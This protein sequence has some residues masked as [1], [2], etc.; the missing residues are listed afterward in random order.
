V[1]LVDTHLHL[2]SLDDPP[3]TIAQAAKAGVR[4]LITMGVDAATNRRALELAEA[5]PEV[6]AAVGHHPVNR[7]PPDLEH[8]RRLIGNP[9]VVAIGEVG[10]DAAH[11]DRAADGDQLS[12]FESFCDLAEAHELPVSIHVRETADAVWRLLRER[13]GL[14]GV[15]HYFALDWEWAQRF[16]ELGFYLSFSGLVTRQAQT[17]L[18]DVVRRC[19]ADRLLLE[20]D[21]PYGTPRGRGGPNQ[22]AWMLD[23]AQVVAEIRGLT[24]TQLATLEGENASRLFTRL[25]DV[26]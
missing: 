20:T 2:D 12:W 14:T 1:G 3:E 5:H 8:V 10:L 17:A 15:M 21:A 18:R 25:G 7:Q 6:H 4:H 16:L 22:P 24:L 11:P 9:R 23:T 19:P 26:A 13:T